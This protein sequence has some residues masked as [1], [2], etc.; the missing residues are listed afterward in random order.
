[1]R[2]FTPLPLVKLLLACSVL[3]SI[4]CFAELPACDNQ[5]L[6]YQPALPELLQA[7]PNSRSFS[8]LVWNT[9]K[10]QNEGWIEQLEQFSQQ[11]DFMLLQEASRE[12]FSQWS[13]LSQWHMYQAIAFE[14]FGDGLGV[15]NLAKQASSENCLVLST[16][17]WIRVPKSALLQHYQWQDKSLLIVNV[18]SINFTLSEADYLKQLQQLSP[19][20]AAYDGP[21]ILAGDF[22]TW[23]VGRLAVLE[24]FILAHQLK[25]VS[26]KPDERTRFFGKALDYIFYRGLTLQSSQ[27]VATDTSDHNALMAS[28][29]FSTR[30][31][32]QR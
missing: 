13:K 20:L 24:Q 22:N 21:L 15:V 10:G 2:L 16:E 23:S 11:V 6:T 26:F 30:S 31:L 5:D 4:S 14:W 32:R 3:F 28:F 17:P 18:H 9:Y 19:W 29:E 12:R 7:E 8:V 27:S 25:T 1:M